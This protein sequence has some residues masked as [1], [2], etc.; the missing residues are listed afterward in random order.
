MISILFSLF[1]S[2]VL[3]FFTSKKVSRAMA[4]F[5]ALLINSIILGITASALYKIDVQRF[6][7]E[8]EGLF[9]SLGIITL[10][11]FIPIVTWLNIIFIKWRQK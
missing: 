5:Y 2:T 4:I 6:H 9:G 7:K 8:A 10:L 1:V 3:S 11:F